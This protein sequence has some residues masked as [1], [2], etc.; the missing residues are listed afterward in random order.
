MNRLELLG[1]LLQR[2]PSCVS[3]SR[4]RTLRRFGR[5]ACAVCWA[6]SG[7]AVS[8]CLHLPAAAAAAVG[9]SAAN[10][11][12]GSLAA[13]TATLPPGDEG[14]HT[15]DHYGDGVVAAGV[16][17]RP[18]PAYHDLE[19]VHKLVRIERDLLPYR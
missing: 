17:S 1:V 5:A 6:A 13:R 8:G 16:L 9:H 15:V 18:P 7:G 19:H 3:V 4:L 10:I 2:L 11:L 14:I 12:E